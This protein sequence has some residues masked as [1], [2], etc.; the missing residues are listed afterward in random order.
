MDV[1]VFMEPSAHEHGNR[2]RLTI[3]EELSVLA[4]YDRLKEALLNLISMQIR[5]LPM[6]RLR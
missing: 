2:I 1:V 3:Q 6:A 4:N 5:Q